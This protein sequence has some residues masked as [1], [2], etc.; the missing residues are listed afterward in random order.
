MS[1]M[2]DFSRIRMSDG[3]NKLPCYKVKIMTRNWKSKMRLDQPVVYFF[4]GIHFCL[5][6]ITTYWP[7]FWGLLLF[8]D[9]TISVVVVA[10][11]YRSSGNPAIMFY[12]LGTL[13]WYVLSWIA[14]A[15]FDPR[16]KLRS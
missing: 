13:W 1:A 15:V 9:F 14:L 6:M 16:P 2:G 5:C 8:F 11:A 10:R 7:R 3:S 12:I 4:P